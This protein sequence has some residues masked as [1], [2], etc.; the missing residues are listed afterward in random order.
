MILTHF[1]CN[2]VS[3]NSSVVLNKLIDLLRD[4]IQNAHNQHSFFLFLY[5]CSI[6]IS[7]TTCFDGLHSYFLSKVTYLLYTQVSDTSTCYFILYSF[8]R[9][10]LSTTEF[11]INL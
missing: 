2:F 6:T 7:N 5:A 9:A 1:R 3:A 8:S 11:V 4:L 10:M